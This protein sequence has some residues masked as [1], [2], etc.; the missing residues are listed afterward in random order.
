MSHKIITI[1]PGFRLNYQTG[2]HKLSITRPSLNASARL[3]QNDIGRISNL[4]Q[5]LGLIRN[6]KA[7]LIIV[8]NGLNIKLVKR[9]IK[10]I[11]LILST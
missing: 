11:Q 5:I 9:S 10:I 6:E 4:I 7:T 2:N 1:Q 8:R 3:A